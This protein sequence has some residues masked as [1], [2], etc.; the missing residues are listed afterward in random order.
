MALL[1]KQVVSVFLG[2]TDQD[3]SKKGVKLGDLITAENW[4]QIK[5]GELTK[6]EGFT[7]TAQTYEGKSAFTPDSFCS[8][9]GSIKLVRDSADDVAYAQGPAGGEWKSKGGTQ[10]LLCKSALRFPST[11][12]DTQIAPMIKQSGDYFVWL[13]D[14]TH[15]RYAKQDVDGV[16]LAYMSAPIAVNGPAGSGPAAS[17]HVCS[18]C[19]VQN[20]SFDASNIWVFWVDW[21]TNAGTQQ[22]RDGVWA[23]K[24]PLDGSATSQINVYPGTASN[25]HILTGI[26]ETYAHGALW[27][28]QCGIYLSAGS[29]VDFRS[30]SAG[31]IDG[32]CRHFKVD[33]A[34]TVTGLQGVTTTTGS[35]SRSWIASGICMLTT[36]E[37]SYSAS[38]LLYA[39][40]TQHASDSTLARLVLVLVNKDTSA[41]TQVEL[42]VVNLDSYILP[43]TLTTQHNY[44]GTV[45]GREHA[46][47]CYVVASVR[48]SSEN[49]GTSAW[50]DV[51]TN[52]ADRIYTK[53]ISYL[54]AGPTVTTVWAARGAWLAHGI[55]RR[56]DETQM[57]YHLRRLSDGAIVTQFS[58]GEGAYPGGCGK[59]ADQFTY[60]AADLQQPYLSKQPYSESYPS[61]VLAT[62]SA[63]VTGT[64]DMAAVAI[65]RPSYQ[66]PTQERGL[67]VAPGGI[68]TIAG[69]WQ[70][71]QE[72]GPLV[73]PGSLTSFWGQGAT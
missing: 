10:R 38:S 2:A 65:T 5:A 14:T 8:P 46:T 63:N 16:R 50:T 21:T 54:P 24:I 15:F 64:V 17:M 37:Y 3:T 1:A 56:T 70:N 41:A 7:E 71:V 6:R 43:A 73:Y 29:A 35:S 49:A 53:C 48:V 26:T 47:G 42:D 55:F 57:P 51:G 32:Y 25:L 22:N 11:A 58:Y 45:T 72:A 20:A 69:G 67:S 30:G 19:V 27:L 59:L 13:D 4:Q 23:L 36:P 40:W 66:N 33:S 31:A 44:I 18:F 62:T 12:S 61:V 52:T 60:H 9:D 39:F 34:G 68:P 28:A